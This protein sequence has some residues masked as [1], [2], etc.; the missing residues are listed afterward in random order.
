MARRREPVEDFAFPP[1]T[2]RVEEP[3]ET[4]VAES[5]LPLLTSPVIP[6]TPTPVSIETTKPVVILS[7]LDSYITERMKEQPRTMAEVTARAEAVEKATATHHRLTLPVYFEVHSHDN[8][9]KPGGYLFRWLFKEKRAIDHALNV[10]G[11]TLVTR[12][13]FSDAP[14][15]LFTANG[16]VE[17]GDAILAFM[18]AKQALALRAKPGQL[19]KERLTARTTQVEPDYTLMSGNPKDQ[20]I[21]QPEMPSESVEDAEAP[22]GTAH[23]EGRD[24]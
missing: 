24:F 15:Y 1:A 20:R 22:V 8:V 4:S 14:R 12:T 11:W 7:Q 5:S 6:S 13:Y 9:A 19:S 21:Y 16:G 17:V 10:L 2:P 23:V 18:P 3:L